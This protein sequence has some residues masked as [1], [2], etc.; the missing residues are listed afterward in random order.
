MVK[1]LK[2]LKPGEVLQM[3]E[4][5]YESTLKKIFK[6]MT[7]KKE[8][9]DFIRWKETRKE[10]AGKTRWLIVKRGG[11]SQVDTKRRSHKKCSE[12]SVFSR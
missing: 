8:D 6:G 7:L 11:D 2:E 1:L 3:R 4:G 5:L 9:F 10:E 12:V